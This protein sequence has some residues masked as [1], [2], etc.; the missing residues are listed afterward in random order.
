MPRFFGH[1]VFSLPVYYGLGSR[2]SLNL[3]YEINPALSLWLKLA[4]TLYADDR[5]SIGTGGEE[6]R[7]NHKTDFRFL[8]CYR[9]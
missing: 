7:G 2:C 8:L 9:F 6:I 1:Y 3:N 4:Q 5:R